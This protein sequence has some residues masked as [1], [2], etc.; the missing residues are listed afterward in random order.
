MNFKTLEERSVDLLYNLLNSTTSGCS[1]F[2]TE[3]ISISLP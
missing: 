1:L 3:P 2:R